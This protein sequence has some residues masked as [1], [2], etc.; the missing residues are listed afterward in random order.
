MTFTTTYVAGTG[1]VS[2]TRKQ[3][4]K[5]KLRYGFV[6]QIRSFGIK[7]NMSAKFFNFTT[8]KSPLKLKNSKIGVGYKNKKT[9]M[10]I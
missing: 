10:H 2:G 4:F 6:N 3:K 1:P 9:H 5:K 8:K 7:Y